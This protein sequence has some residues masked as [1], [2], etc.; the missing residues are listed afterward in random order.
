MGLAAAGVAMSG[1]RWDYLGPKLESILSE[2]GDDLKVRERFPRL[3]VFLPILGKILR[4][5]E[6]DLDWD[7]SG[8]DPISHDKEFTDAVFSRIYEALMKAY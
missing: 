4:D 8:D 7:L 6:H 2:I 5:M 1:G 3:G